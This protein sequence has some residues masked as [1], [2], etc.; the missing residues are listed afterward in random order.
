MNQRINNACTTCFL[1]VFL[2]VLRFTA[3]HWAYKEGKRRGDNHELYNTPWLASIKEWQNDRISSR[4][5]VDSVRKELLGKRVFVF[6]RNGKILNLARGASII[7]AA[8][9]IHTMVGLSMYGAEINGKPVPFSYELQNGDVVSILTGEQGRPATDWMRYA[10]SRSTR[11]KLRSYFRARQKESL[12]EAGKILLKD[13]LSMHR[14]LIERESYLGFPFTLPTEVED[15]EV[16]LPGKTSY[17]TID[18]LLVAIGTKH[19][20]NLLRSFLHKLIS[21]IFEVPKFK[22][23]ASEDDRRGVATNFLSDVTGRHDY[24]EEAITS[25]P[26]GRRDVESYSAFDEVNGSSQGENLLVGLDLDKEAADPD[27]ICSECLPVRGDQVVGT[28][29]MLVGDDGHDDD[30]ESFLKDSSITMVHRIG[31]HHAQKAINAAHAELKLG[32]MSANNGKPMVDSVTLRRRNDVIKSFGQTRDVPVKLYWS[33][34]VDHDAL[35]LAEVVL[36][37][38]DR[39]LLLAD[40]SEVVSE[41]VEIVKTGSLTTQ[42]HATLIFLV[43]VTGLHQLQDLMDRLGKVPSVMSVERR[44]GSELL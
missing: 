37:C 3:S 27:Q 31:C 40:C 22:L 30:E 13:Y 24:A 4:D 41:T 15:L 11:S 8:F 32:R 16:F 25:S 9:A 29:P 42:E 5:F 39:K 10:K 33:D 43:Q 35:F 14:E 17:E 34:D 12:R 36:H 19:D 20:H 2:V 21:K 23:M 28:R 44:F 1:T 26:S 7:D 6:L 18:E 38:N